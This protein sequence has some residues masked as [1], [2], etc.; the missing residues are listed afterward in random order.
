MHKKY[1]R[2]YPDELR[3]KI[4][5]IGK[6]D[7][8][9]EYIFAMFAKRKTLDLDETFPTDLLQQ[10]YASITYNLH[11]IFALYPKPVILSRSVFV[12]IDL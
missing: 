4:S 9:L 12:F 3:L 7:T 6:N 2:K 8:C 5:R 11:A 10:K 1:F